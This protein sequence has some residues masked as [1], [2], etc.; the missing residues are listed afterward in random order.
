MPSLTRRKFLQG[1]GIAAGVGAL[2]LGEYASVLEPNHPRVVSV[3]VPIP[4]LPQAF[5]GFR[6]AQLTDFHYDSLFSAVP[7]RRAVEIT[8]S[9]SP[10]LVVLTGDFV[11]IPVWADILHDKKQAADAAEPCS[12][13]LTGLRS[14]LGSIAVLGNHDRDSDGPRIR[15][16]L[17]SQ[18]IPVL[19]NS[20]RVIEENGA[21]LWLA[22]ID[23]AV[24]GKPDIRQTLKGIPVEEAVI[25]LAHE[26]DFA[27]EACKHPIDLQLS[28]H[29]HGGQ[30]WLPG[31]GAPW[32]PDGA[33]KYPRGLYTV[34]S[35]TLYTNFGIGTIRVPV[36]LNCP[37][38]VALLTLRS[39]S[40][41]AT[42]SIA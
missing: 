36:R 18:G 41:S 9:L 12:D 2:G 33:E 26:P 31:V 38:E 27:D 5:N 30:I 35:T 42:V 10:D 23:D 8:N 20:N 16:I 29:S 15:H 4:R 34:G 1:T 19:Q 37:P 40:G 17:E 13:V 6:I 14:R 25:L 28:G 22:G 3:E 39:G 32:L 11:S 21:R 7:I 24:E